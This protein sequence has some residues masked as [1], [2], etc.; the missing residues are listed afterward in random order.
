MSL[1][2]SLFNETPFFILPDSWVGWFGLIVWMGV[3]G[4]ALY[5]WRGYWKK[6]GSGQWI[7]FIALLVIT[8]VAN[9]FIGARLPAWGIL[10]LPEMTLETGGLA[11]MLFSALPWMLAGGFLGPLAAGMTALLAGLCVGYWGTHTLFTSL[12]F[13]TLAIL[14][15][16]AVLQRY[17]TFCFRYLRHPIIAAILLIL[18]Y[19]LLF[20]IGALFVVGGSLAVKLDYAITHVGATTLAVA[21]PILLAGL[22]V[23]FIKVA[24]PKAW[25]GQ[26]PWRPSPAEKSLEARFFYTF[27][28]SL[29]ILLIVFVVGDWVVA[30]KAAR[31]MLQS[32]MLSAAEVASESVPYFLNTGQNLILQ[33]ASDQQLDLDS[34]AQI[35]HVLENG[36][37]SVPY[38]QQL[39]ILDAQGETLAGRPVEN[40][41][42]VPA[43]LEEQVGIDMALNG[44]PVQVYAVPRLDEASSAHLSFFAAI[45]DQDEK[46]KGVLVGRTSLASNPFAKS[47]LSNLGSVSDISGV[48]L[49][50]DVDGNILYHSESDLV[51]REYSGALS[52]QPLFYDGT[53]PDGT[54]QLVCYQPAVGQ[55]WGIVLMV[56]A[57]QAQQLALNIAAPLLGVIL[58]LVGMIFI[59]TRLSL[60]MVT[61]SLKSLTG[62]AERIAQGHLDHALRVDG[63]DEVG[64]LRGSFEKMRLS[65][66]ARLDELNRL[67]LVSQGVA[68]SLEIEKAIGPILDAALTVGAS[69]VRIVLASDIVPEIGKEGDEPVHYGGGRST[70][71]YSYFDDQILALMGEPGQERIVVNN[72][73]RTSLYPDAPHPGAMLAIPL[74]HESLY[75]GVLWVAYDKTHS[76]AAEEIQFLTTLAGQ[77]GLAATNA[78]LFM[79]AEFERERLAA[80]LVSTPDPVLVTDRHDRL[81][82]VN[83]V[84]WEILGMGGE[85]SLGQPVEDVID[86]K[87]L[88]GLLRLSESS[89]AIQES[90]EVKLSQGNVYMATASTIRFEGQSIGR[91]C[92]LQDVTYFKELDALKSE[93]VATVSHDLRSPL[94]LM[95]GYATMLEM[96]G[97]LNDQQSGYI[98]KI[99]VGIESMSRL[100][101]N[102]L[103]LGRI[104][105]GVGLKLQ[106][107]PVQDVVE[108]VIEM[109]QVQ[110]Q[111]KQIQLHAAISDAVPPLVEADRALLQQALHNLVENAIKYTSKGG[112]VRLSLDVRQ[113]NILFEVKDTGIGISSTDK[114]RVFEKFY[115]SADREAKKEQGT[116]LGLAIVKSIV[117]RH[118]GQMGV[119]SQ[120]GEGS[121]FYFEIPVSQS[122]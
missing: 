7:A 5:N 119:E 61:S 10:P 117:E 27:A 1:I 11:L 39:I 100:V 53:A 84:A 93:F 13:A 75:L 98:G 69:S 8:P 48:G 90:V 67:L 110:S 116:G 2:L 80:I 113:D 36:L 63:D 33:L 97:N 56:P 105:T 88:V 32:R 68:S 16:V 95:R 50:V 12:E 92:V 114:Q 108:Q 111:Q 122:K 76:F 15:S 25:G 47:I 96:V 112:E 85:T 26:P 9:L 6:W 103:D 79:T 31:Q 121:I 74:R 107:L 99:V 44:V 4:L 59:L 102:L 81:L 34:E 40:F 64:R 21:G 20:V 72:P 30:G 89:D 45:F 83:P 82:L 49:L 42:A 29:A 46:V 73:K 14:F 87:E 86:H 94:T 58:V 78:R 104:E 18:L 19:P 91:V 57:R 106:M 3:L 17:R 23:E 66:K 65:L 60:G 37:R 38:F 41:T 54:R 51:V 24:Y 55:P 101:N 62:V 120:K 71:K 109:F 35:L 115:R 118:G 52:S 22:T 70:Q 43:T 28:P 77:A